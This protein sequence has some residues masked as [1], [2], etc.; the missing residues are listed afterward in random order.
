MF[1][2]SAIHC[3]IKVKTDSS[4][5]SCLPQRGRSIRLVSDSGVPHLL[6]NSLASA[7]G[8]LQKREKVLGLYD[9]A[10]RS[11][12]FGPKQDSVR[13]GFHQSWELSF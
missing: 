7:F 13:S 4:V 12:R 8:V 9:E 10:L 3:I 1:C 5:G 6:S 11:L 2:R